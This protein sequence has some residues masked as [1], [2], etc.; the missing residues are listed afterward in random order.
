MKLGGEEQLSTEWLPVTKL[1]IWRS[2]EIHSN[3][4]KIIEEYICYC[5][6]AHPGAKAPLGYVTVP[7]N[8]SWM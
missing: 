7:D 3:C 4:I 5:L 2:N 8:V 1:F 6:A